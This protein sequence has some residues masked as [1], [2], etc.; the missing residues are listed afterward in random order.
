MTLSKHVNLSGY[1]TSSPCTFNKLQLSC[2][3]LKADFTVVK[4]EGDELDLNAASD[5]LKKEVDLR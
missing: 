1:L 3:S 2:G 5:E 4:Q